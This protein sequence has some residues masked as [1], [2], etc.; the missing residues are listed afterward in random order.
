MRPT[1]FFIG[2]FLL[3][4]STLMLEIIQ[5]RLL[6]V[7]SWYHLAFLVISA[8]MFGMTAGAVWVFLRKDSYTR[9]TLANDLSLASARMA[10][11]TTICMIAQLTLNPTLVGSVSGVSVFLFLILLIAIPF[12][13]SGLAVSLALTRSP[14][15][16]GVVYAVDL[17]GAATGCL[18]VLG[19]LQIMD[20]PSA[21]FLCAAGCAVASVLFRDRELPQP[22]HTGS[23]SRFAVKAAPWFAVLL[24]AVSI[25]NGWTSRGIQPLNVKGGLE[26]PDTYTYRKWNSFSRVAATKPIAMNIPD[27]MRRSSLG[28]WGPSPALQTVTLPFIEMAVMN[29]DGEA[30]TNM[31]RFTGDANEVNHLRYD[32]TNL[33]YFIRH[34]GRAAVIGVGSGRDVLSAWLFGFQDVTGVELNPIFIELLTKHPFY[35]DFCRVA[36]LKGIR[37]IVDEGRS[38]FVRSREK[39]DLIQ[40]SLIDTW[41]ATGAGAFTLSENGLYTIEAWTAFLN[42]LSDRGV[43][44]VSRWFHA[45]EASET[46]RTV[47]LAAA[48]LMQRGVTKVRDHMFVASCGPIATL[49]ISPAPFSA[50]DIQALRDKCQNLSYQVLIAP[51]QFPTSD[52]LHGILSAT[53]LPSL[54]RFTAGLDL[55]LTP[56]TD[57]TPFFFNLVPLGNPFKMWRVYKQTSGRGVISGNLD[58]SLSLLAILGVSVL[59]VLVTIVVPLISSTRGIN[60]RLTVGGTAYFALLGFGFMFVEIGL[61]QRLSVFLGHPIYSLSVVLFSLIIATGVGSYCSEKLPL[62]SPSR[63]GAWSLLLALYLLSLPFWLGPLIGACDHFS[64]LFKAIISIAVIAPAGMMMGFG[65]PTGIR[66]AEAVDASP[67]PW[68]WGINGAT[69]VLASVL[70]V[71]AS[72]AFGIRTT[73]IIGGLAYLALIPCAMLIGFGKVADAPAKT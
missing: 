18:G 19:L 73:L 45:V 56:P 52:V 4:H 23:R 31:F 68:F 66:L 24:V 28:L 40:M 6:S 8:A 21:I 3:T 51:D 10:I 59:L 12:F 27:Q 60:R 1:R 44:T 9:A 7:I 17:L 35:S 55:N 62:N 64:I 47:S 41:A 14:F 61:L 30:G 38:W 69:G 49:L 67:T 37:L 63:I 22:A 58:A 20:A 43:F 5:T 13:Y 50:E 72:I 70:A 54:Y 57:E 33:A 2:L 32:V 34:D 11:A 42:R 16:I 53:D 39:F 36:A 15:P 48:A 71:A 29:I 46:G 26:L 65:F 25:L